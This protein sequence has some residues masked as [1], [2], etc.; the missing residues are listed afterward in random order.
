MSTPYQIMRIKK[1]FELRCKGK[2]VQE[3]SDYMR[4]VEGWKVGTSTRTIYHDLKSH[5]YMQLVEAIQLQQLKEIEHLTDKVTRIRWR[6]KLLET[7][8]PK[9]IV[10]HVEEGTDMKALLD[11]LGAKNP[12]NYT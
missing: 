6:Q 11:G 5:Y 12:R 10:S 3:I 8:T 1:V 9:Q 2:S 7:I 4:R